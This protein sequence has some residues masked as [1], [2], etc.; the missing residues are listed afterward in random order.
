MDYTLKQMDEKKYKSIKIS[1][2]AGIEE[3]TFRKLI[4]GELIIT[5][6]RQS[7]CFDKDQILHLSEVLLR[8]YYTEITGEE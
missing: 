3:I 2:G 5:E 1:K 6:D 4:S 7:I 8:F